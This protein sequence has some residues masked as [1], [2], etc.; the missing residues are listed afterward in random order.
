MSPSPVPTKYTFD[1]IG[2]ISIVRSDAN[3]DE[4]HT[5]RLNKRRHTQVLCYLL[6]GVWFTFVSFNGI[7]IWRFAIRDLLH[8][9][10]YIM[11]KPSCE[12]ARSCSAAFCAAI[13][14]RNALQSHEHIESKHTTA[15]W[16][17]F[18]PFQLPNRLNRQW[19]F[20]FTNS[21]QI[22]RITYCYVNDTNAA[23]IK[24][25]RQQLWV[26]VWE[27]YSRHRYSVFETSF[28]IHWILGAREWLCFVRKSVS[29]NNDLSGHIIF[30]IRCVQNASSRLSIACL[31]GIL[32]LL[33]HSLYIYWM[34]YCIRRKRCKY[35]KHCGI[36]IE[37]C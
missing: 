2:C 31:L 14:R 7:W 23:V 21:H 18:N 37:L 22:G 11:T 10:V 4:N 36:Q 32:C 8:V 12:I 33:L 9:I 3:L 34:D 13:G 24:P 28:R 5:N 17:T 15:L 6:A 30:S 1:L 25:N 27:G 26:F 35:W 16:F 20:S 29:T 19:R